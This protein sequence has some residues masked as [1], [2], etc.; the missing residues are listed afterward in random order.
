MTGPLWWRTATWSL[1]AALVLVGL[2]RPIAGL[3][4]PGMLLDPVNGL[5]RTARLSERPPETTLRITGLENAVTVERDVRG[6]PHIFAESDSDAVMALGYVVAQDRLFQL[7]FLPRVAS[8]R[9]SEIFGPAS[10][11][12]DRFLRRTGMDWGARATAR[13]IEREGGLEYDVL[14][15]FG[16]GVN[17]Y[18]ERTP[19]VDLPLEFRLFDYRPDQYGALTATRL[20]QYFA[21]DL[22]FKHTTLDLARMEQLLG[23]AAYDSLFPL[24]SPGYVPII[25]GSR[26]YS[27]AGSR[28]MSLRAGRDLEPPHVARGFAHGKGS[29]NWAVHGARSATG[30]PILA[31]D[32]HLDLALPAIWYEAHI[33]TTDVNTYGVLTP[34]TP[35]L[36][37]A[38]NDHLGWTFTNMG[39]DVVDHYAI[40]L[41]DSVRRYL[42][43][44]E[45]KDVTFVPDTIRVRGSAPVVDTL[46]YTHFG[47]LLVDE[48]IAIRWVAHGRSRT[49]QALW[50][51]NH[52]RSLG[53]FDE[54]AR[55]W[56]MPAQNIL[57]ADTDGNIAIRSTGRIPIRKGGHGVGILDGTTDADEW[58]GTIPFA[59]LPHSVNPE[60]GYL[61]STNQQPTGPEYPY[62]LGYEWGDAFRSMRIDE[63]LNAKE[64][65]TMSD[66][67]RYQA[68]VHAVQRDL[69][70]PLLGRTSG[71]SPRAQFLSDLLTNWSG[72]TDTSRV[73]PLVLYEFI[74][75]LEA[76]TWDEPIFDDGPI[77]D[78]MVLYGLLE[79]DTTSDWIDVQAT[80]EREDVAGLLRLSLEATA[81]TLDALYGFDPAAWRWGDRHGVT[82]RHLTRAPALSALWRG[83]YPFPGFERTLAPGSDLTVT[84]SASWRM[85][86]DFSRVPP[87]GYGVYPGGQSGDPL[88]S[89]YDSHI[90][91][92]LR[93]AYFDLLKPRAAGDLEEVSSRIRFI[94]E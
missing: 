33:V 22:T 66:L 94:P 76:M 41:D 75:I 40:E 61:T 28:S 69:F 64:H 90:A 6:V 27:A 57:Y 58:I 15:W 87:V 65:H 49:L 16:T 80:S 23:Q 26:P 89:L 30:M 53:E 35:V 50:G 14:N 70:V 51:M 10:I 17:A 5:W 4:P 7:D 78:L 91:T 92:Y 44:G 45:W 74:R 84:H 29:N 13:A 48:G 55:F 59:E 21:Y 18:I 60:Q 88:S 36:V 81:D 8:G 37:E 54:A 85:V 11:E 83:P 9:L 39:A 73:E 62:Y 31:G 71:L 1:L 46:A 24:H 56:D 42:Y 63:L 43:E 32:M 25:P 2:S 19:D 68:D 38:F 34:G 79:N 52:A 72:T 20:I 3:A 82:F 86:V 12:A 47:P 77:P 67:K 93:F